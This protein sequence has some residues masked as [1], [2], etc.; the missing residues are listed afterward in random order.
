MWLWLALGGLGLYAWT[1]RSAAPA[2]PK[3][4]DPAPAPAPTPG[5][6]VD[7]TGGQVYVPPVGIDAEKMLKDLMLAYSRVDEP[8]KVTEGP[9]KGAVVLTYVLA[10]PTMP[11]IT[12]A[13]EAAVFFKAGFLL[14]NPSNEFV[15]MIFEIKTVEA[16]YAGKRPDRI[17][18]GLAPASL[19]A[20]ICA[21]GSPYVM[22]GTNKV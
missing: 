21:P 22:V 19:A 10:K 11:K 14:D 20:K 18:I 8:V 17:D 12:E 13:S 15:M 1:K 7:K 16:V 3:T 4:P 6:A 5:V 2:T 9:L